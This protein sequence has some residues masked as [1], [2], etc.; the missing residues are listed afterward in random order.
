MEDTSGS[1]SIIEINA[2]LDHLDECIKVGARTV[3]LGLWHTTLYSIMKYKRGFRRKVHSAVQ[4]GGTDFE[5]CAQY[6]NKMKPDA[7]IVFTDGYYG[8]TRTRVDCPIL[9]VICSQGVDKLVT[10]Y[11][12][13]Q[14]IKLPPMGE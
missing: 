2:G 8:P 12:R 9:F 13:Q 1:M 5:P 10:D 6:I 11:P 3:T 7:V 4:S 14:M